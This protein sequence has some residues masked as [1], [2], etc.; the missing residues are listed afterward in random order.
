MVIARDQY[1][2]ARALLSSTQ[3]EL[4]GGA[5]VAKKTI[6]DFEAGKRTPLW[7]D[8]GRHA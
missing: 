7:P 4:S 3:D 6:A 5:A 8:A 1:R 2:A